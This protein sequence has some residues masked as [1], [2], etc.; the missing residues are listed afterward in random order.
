MSW[1]SIASLLFVAVGQGSGNWRLD[2]ALTSATPPGSP[3]PPH[4]T[5]GLICLAMARARP[6][7]TALPIC[8]AIWTLVP[9]QR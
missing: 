3:Y 8:L 2:T 1:S 4:P 5:S 7:G 9:T 6:A